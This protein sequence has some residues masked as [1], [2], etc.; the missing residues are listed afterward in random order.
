MDLLL[1]YWPNG[2]KGGKPFLSPQKKRDCKEE[3][4]I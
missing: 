1:S 3:D 2:S 4:D